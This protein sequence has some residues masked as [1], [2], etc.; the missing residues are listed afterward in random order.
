METTEKSVNLE[1]FLLKFDYFNLSV[2]IKGYDKYYKID[3]HLIIP[4]YINGLQIKKIGKAAFDLYYKIKKITIEKGVNIIEPYAF[5]GCKNLT[6]I[7][8]PEGLL[9]IKKGAFFGCKKLEKIQFPESVLRIS[10]L[11]FADCEKLTSVFIP[12]KVISLSSQTFLGCNKLKE[13]IVDNENLEYSS[14]D[15]VLFNEAKTVLVEY[16]AGKKD[17]NYT[18]PN[19]VIDIELGAFFDR[20]KLVTIILPAKLSGLPQYVFLGCDKIEQ[21][22]LQDDNPR[23]MT[24]DGVLF[25]KERKTLIFYPHGKKETE[26]VIPEGVERIKEGVFKDCK[27]IEN[28][29]FP[30]S[31]K[32]IERMAFWG[33]ENLTSIILPKNLKGICNHAFYSCQRLEKVTLS[34]KTRIGRKAFEDFKGQFIYLD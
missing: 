26:Y 23:F 2:T 19:T 15:G 33:C 22:I 3:E 8:L 30:E 14:L 12:K 7:E 13:I 9:E 25:D 16:P 5:F 18:I 4:G 6:E 24:M 10:K 20:K 21:I 31:L 27:N 29:I 1:N 28:I 32:M 34:R 17:K 11:A